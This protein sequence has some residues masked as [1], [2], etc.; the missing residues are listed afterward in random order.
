MCEYC[1]IAQYEDDLDGIKRL[2]LG[3]D[4]YTSLE[5][6]FNPSNNKFSM[7]ASGEGEVK[8]EL[9]YCPKCGRKLT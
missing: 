8:T 1:N 7:V 9:D 6:Q 2:R 4:C 5:M 3:W